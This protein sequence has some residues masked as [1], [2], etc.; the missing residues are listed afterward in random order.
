LESRG[1]GVQVVRPEGIP[2]KA[3]GLLLSCSMTV[4][5]SGISSFIE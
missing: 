3:L 4:M 2:V 1:H 5:V